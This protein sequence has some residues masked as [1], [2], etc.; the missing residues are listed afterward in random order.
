MNDKDDPFGLSSDAGRTR[1]RPVSGAAGQRPVTPP[2]YGATPAP[3][4]AFGS[5]GGGAFGGGAP[6]P[7]PSRPRSQR[8]HANPLIAAFAPL[9]EIAPELERAA[10]PGQPDVLRH[11]LQNSLIDAR[12]AAVAL[13]Q[14]LTRDNQGAWFVAALVDD[15][16]LN[17]PWGGHSDWPRQPLV[18]ALSGEVDAGT[19]FFRH[20]EDLVA[21]PTRDPDLLELAYTCLC[22]GFRGQYRLQGASGEASITAMRGQIARLLRNVET[23]AAPLSPHAEGV[24]VPDTPRRFAVPLWTV[25]LVAVALS[26][27]IYT[28]LSLQL[29]DKAEQLFVSAA[30]LPPAER[31]GIF[32]PVRD[33]VSLTEPVVPV[34]PVEPVMF[35]LLPLFKSAA[36]TETA[37]ALTGREDVSLVVLVVQGTAPELFRSAKAEV[38]EEYAPLMAAIAKVIGENAEVTGRVTV[39]GHTDSVPVQSSNPFQS[40]QGLS[41]ARAATIAEILVANGVPA[42]NVSSEGRADTEP[43]GDNATKDGRAQNR[44]IEIKIE[45]RL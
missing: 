24:K 18:T 40:N 13:G 5:F 43:V 37:A 15:I 38:N 6:A 17:T 11:R 7:G 2:S 25:W 31:A 39:I 26:A 36:P 1:I 42:E 27:G 12:D 41:E 45:K 20:L 14:P 23:L 35:E 44:R 29:G 30:A 8:P 10:P 28:L 9:L 4:G 34:E 3:G 16:A 32:R 33:T 22:L 19:R 21:H